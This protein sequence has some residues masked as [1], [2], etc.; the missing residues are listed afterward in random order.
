MELAHAKLH[1]QT[2]LVRQVANDKAMEDRVIARE[3]QRKK[4]ERMKS[5]FRSINKLQI[6]NLDIE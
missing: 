4:V 1:T 2:T 6:E 5:W 3:C